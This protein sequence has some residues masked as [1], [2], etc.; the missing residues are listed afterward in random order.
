VVAPLRLVPRTRSSH[1]CPAPS[2]R[3]SG[4]KAALARIHLLVS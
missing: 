3:T 1:E 4:A 2:M